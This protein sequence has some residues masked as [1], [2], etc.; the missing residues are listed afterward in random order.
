MSD[1][2]A[3]PAGS[4]T[5]QGAAN[6]IG[7][8]LG[9]DGNVND[10][11]PSRALDPEHGEGEGRQR[12]NKG[13]FTADDSGDDGKAGQTDEDRAAAEAA[14]RQGDATSDDDS[15]EPTA[16]GGDDES[17]IESFAQ[18][19]EAI[20]VDEDTLRGL[21]LTYEDSNGD[22]ITLKLADLVTGHKNAEDVQGNRAKLA[23]ERRV[24]D[25]ES[26][27][28]LETMNGQAAALAQQFQMVEQFIL[29]EAQEPRLVALRESD[30]AEYMLRENEL[31]QRAGQL[32]Q[33]RAQAAQQYEAYRT[34]LMQEYVTREAKSLQEVY[35]DWG[36][37]HKAKVKDTITS[38]GFA[39]DEVKV[40]DSRYVRG[41][42]ELADLRV[43]VAELRKLKT[44]AKETSTRIK[45]TVPKLNLK[46]GKQRS[47]DAGKKGSLN[48]LK[49]RFNE[50]HHERDAAKVIEQMGII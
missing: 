12:D 48:R 38:L 15:G 17:P 16:G 10:G 2:A 19:A 46:P 9:D 32:Q 11:V 40:F 39:A 30:P 43:E 7:D 1:Q 37:S 8:L 18:L 35:P 14:A 6:Q 34:Q 31:R 3:D 33:A 23:D 20:D 22:E 25:T 13:R 4:L 26:A 29:S 45:A 44:R 50:T 5:V 27:A 28:R 41:L 47:T 42:V 24:F 21:N 49:K 36:D